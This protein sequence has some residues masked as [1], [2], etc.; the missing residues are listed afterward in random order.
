MT[1]TTIQIRRA[2]TDDALPLASLAAATFPLACPPSTARSAIDAFIAQHLSLERFEGYLADPTREIFVAEGSV[3]DTILG[4]TMV[5]H[6]LLGYTML[7]YGEPYDA[8]VAVA[9]THRPTVEL[10]K[11]YTA[12]EA[13][14]RGVAPALIAASVDSARERG[15]EGMWLGVSQLNARANRF[16]EKNGFERVGI[17]LFWVGDERNEDFVRE[18][19]L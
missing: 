3:G 19:A 11:C 10:S 13:H 1:E 14:G 18:R 16:Y 5:G 15:A 6:A 9:I 17:K 12:A 7:V 2:T 4:Q 8:D